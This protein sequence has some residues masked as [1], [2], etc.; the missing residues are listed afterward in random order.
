M[1]HKQYDCPP[2]NLIKPSTGVLIYAHEFTVGPEMVVPLLL[3][4]SAKVNI[5]A[6]EPFASH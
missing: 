1:P 6:P 2:V 4:D 3:P 5:L